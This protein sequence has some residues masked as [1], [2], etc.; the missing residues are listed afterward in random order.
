MKHQRPPFA[1]LLSALVTLGCSADSEPCPDG[2]RSAGGKLCVPLASSPMESELPTGASV[3]QTWGDAAVPPPNFIDVT[4]AETCDGK[5]NDDDGQVDEGLVEA[6]GTEMGLCTTGVRTCVNGEFA[7]CTGNAPADEVCDGLDDEDCDGMVD[8]GCEC[9]HG[10][11]RACSQDVGVCRQGIQVCINGTFGECIGGIL[12]TNELCNGADDDCD[13][14]V[15][16]GNPE[17]DVACSSDVGACTVGVTVCVEEKLVCTGV[18]PQESESS[19]DGIDE[20]CDGRV[21][22]D[23]MVDF[24][25]DADGDGQGNPDVFLEAACEHTYDGAGVPDR[26]DCNDACPKC[27]V[28]AYEDRGDLEDNDCDGAIDEWSPA[29]A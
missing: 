28:G 13:G 20:D 6:C 3:A 21:D 16:E 14:S 27:G 8:E 12:P 26:R 1:V 7:E 17:G 23:L 2:F 25:E 29:S 24:Y 4:N 15:D 18:M 10:T 9:A 19:C 11:M 5:D 22:E